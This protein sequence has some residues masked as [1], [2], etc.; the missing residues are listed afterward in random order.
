MHTIKSLGK[1]DIIED[2]QIA[3][4]DSYNL[5]DFGAYQVTAFNNVDPVSYQR[6]MR[7]KW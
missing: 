1:V 3:S 6:A 4:N 5:L 2:K 7:D